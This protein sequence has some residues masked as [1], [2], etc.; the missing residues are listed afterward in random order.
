[1]PQR[2]VVLRWIEQIARVVARLLHGPGPPDLELAREQ[3]SAALEQHLGPL[4]VVL[5]RL[6]VPSAAAILNDP[7]RLFGY[8]QLLALLAAVQQAGGEAE[9]AHTRERALQL[10][11]EAIGRAR[12]VP[13]EWCQWLS[14]TEA[15]PPDS[16]PVEHPST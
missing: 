6:D 14:E 4:H 2:D 16:L 5:P 12:D 7:D 9:A 11:R 13:A 8:A 3:I 15:G 10:G 1:M